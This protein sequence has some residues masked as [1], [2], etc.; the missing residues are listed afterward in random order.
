MD[1]NSIGKV[2][3]LAYMT[4]ATFLHIQLSV[5]GIHNAA[6]N[7]CLFASIRGSSASRSHLEPREL[8]QEFRPVRCP[9]PFG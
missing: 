4:K 8:F 3:V 5:T 6:S 7:S 1:T 2:R 9:V